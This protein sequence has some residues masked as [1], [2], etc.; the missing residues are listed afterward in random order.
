MLLRRYGSSYQSVV[1]HFDARAI[2]E[3]SFRRDRAHT[4]GADDFDEQ[5]EKLREERIAAESEGT[6]QAEAEAAVLEQMES[7]LQ[8]LLAQLS[9]G[10]ILVVESEQGVD[11]PKLRDRKQGIIVDGE[12]RLYFHWRVDPPLRIGL[13]RRRVG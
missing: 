3:V 11:Y 7:K 1:P 6:V 12:N 10:E 2:T 9:E 5:F 8:E 4:I 13:Y